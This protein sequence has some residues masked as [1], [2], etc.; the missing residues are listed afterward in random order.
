M[1]GKNLDAAIWTGL[2]YSK[3]TNNKRPAIE[4]ILEHLDKT[5]DRTTQ[6][7]AE[8]YIRRAP[9]Q[10]DTEY[11]RIIEKELGWTPIEQ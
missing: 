1:I 9:K 3:K 8:E 6:I 7:V 10:I 4:T 11:R 2:S 5:I